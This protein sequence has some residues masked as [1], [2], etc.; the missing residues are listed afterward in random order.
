V[1]FVSKE[2]W[3][4]TGWQNKVTSVNIQHGHERYWTTFVEDRKDGYLGFR[5]HRER[6]SRTSEAGQVTFWDAS[7]GFVFETF[8]GDVPVEIVEAVI[9]EARDRIKTK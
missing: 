2:R 8:D 4:E 3:I 6:F 9:R 1:K 5:L 7:G